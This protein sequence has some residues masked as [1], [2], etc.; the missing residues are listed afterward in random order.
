MT[1]KSKLNIMIISSGKSLKD[2]LLLLYVVS[3]STIYLYGCFNY[4]N[5]WEVLSVT[6]RWSQGLFVLV[7]TLYSHGRD[8]Y[9]HSGKIVLA[10]P[11]FSVQFIQN[12]FTS[13]LYFKHSQYYN[14]GV[15]LFRFYLESF[16]LIFNPFTRSW[17]RTDCINVTIL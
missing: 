3:I 1:I 13:G 12:I 10:P 15:Q 17:I 5:R 11:G 14:I 9:K 16:V 2:S 7:P 8:F 6:T 4:N